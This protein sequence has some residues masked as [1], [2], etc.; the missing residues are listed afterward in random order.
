MSARPGIAVAIHDG[1][2]GCGTG[3]GYANLGFLRTLVDLLPEDARLAVLP[4]RLAPESPEYHQDWHAHVL[5]ILDRPHVSIHPVDNGT[6]GMD[7]WGTLDNFRTV[8]AHTGLRLRE[9]LAAHTDP[10]LIF[11]FDV[12]FFG[13]PAALPTAMR[14]QLILVPRSSALIHTPDDHERVAWERTNLHTG[15]GA[16]TRV[17]VISP[18]MGRHLHQDYGIPRHAL[19]DIPDG[20]T[21]EDKARIVGPHSSDIPDIRLPEEFILAIG[22]AEPYKGFDDLIDALAIL[23]KTRSD[24]P[25]LILAATTETPHPTEYQRHL[26]R[27]IEELGIV[28]TMLFRFSP[29]VT[30]LLRTPGVRA[31]VVPSRAE[32]FGRIPMEAFLAGA[33]PV[34]TTTA[35]G[36]A[37]QIEPGSTGF[38]CAPGAPET[39]AVALASALC[40]TTEQRRAMTR[41]ARRRAARTY[42]HATVIRRVLASAA[43][44]LR[45]GAASDRLR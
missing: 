27:R 26:A 5:D 42:D 37:E 40:L 13:L 43:P 19:L 29:S 23:R 24:I 7:R 32:P 25:H 38:T 41:R 6:A 35:H 39:L 12:P 9:D 15:L 31:V 36:L 4:L 10:L 18:F 30:A 44:W 17:G 28:A 2:Y 8:S 22:R 11:A 45:L 3:A 34:I 21:V 33:G 16:G 14:T 20:L 1:F